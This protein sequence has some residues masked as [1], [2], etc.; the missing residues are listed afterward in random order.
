LLEKKGVRVSDLGRL[1][2]EDK[3]FIQDSL[4]FND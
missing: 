1:A 4:G 3:I 2:L